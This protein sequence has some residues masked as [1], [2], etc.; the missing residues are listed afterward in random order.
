MGNILGTPP[1]AGAFRVGGNQVRPLPVP[2]GGGAARPMSPVIRPI[3]AQP[4]RTIVGPQR[5]QPSIQAPTGG[6]LGVQSRPIAPV[7][8][9]GATGG[10]VVPGGQSLGSSN[11]MQIVRPG[12]VNPGTVGGAVVGGGAI[13]GGAIQRPVAPVA[14]QYQQPQY[15]QP[16]FLSTL[17]PTITTGPEGTTLGVQGVLPNG[18]TVGGAVTRTPDGQVVGAVNG[19]GPAGYMAPQGAGGYSPGYGGGYGG[20]YRGPTTGTNGQ[21]NYTPLTGL[22]GGT[23]LPASNGLFG[24]FENTIGAGVRRIFGMR[25][26]GCGIPSNAG[27]GVQSGVPRG[28]PSAPYQSQLPARSGGV[29]IGAP[30]GIVVGRQA[31][32]VMY[33]N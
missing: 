9:P 17:S 13:V 26:A 14:P 31:P 18:M 4:S 27:V 21:Q 11:G 29:P 22:N 33:G 24:V 20:G 12:I 1:R 6:R 2:M 23:C 3:T 19:Q 15:Q 32:S 8:R 28:V 5:V 25:Q 10:A 7:T 30:G 16:G